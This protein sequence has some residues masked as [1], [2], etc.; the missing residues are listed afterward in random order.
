MTSIKLIVSST[1]RRPGLTQNLYI[2][3]HSLLSGRTLQSQAVF[4]RIIT[5]AIRDDQEGHSVNDVDFSLPDHIVN[6]HPPPSDF[7]RWST[8]DGGT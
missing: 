7:R 2:D 4:A 8:S 6:A 3:K 5:G 1:T